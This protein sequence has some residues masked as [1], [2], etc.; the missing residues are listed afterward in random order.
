M[1]SL[2]RD[3]MQL[4]EEE[5]RLLGAG[6]HPSLE[7]SLEEIEKAKEFRFK[8]A[9]TRLKMT[10]KCIQNHFDT[11]LY[12]VSSTFQSRKTEVRREML[13]QLQSLYIGYLMQS[14][15]V[16]FDGML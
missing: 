7:I 3:K 9:E 13:N 2:F 1:I 16:R 10:K 8:V 12:F 5:Q 14:E 15:K 11:D 6:T 4:L